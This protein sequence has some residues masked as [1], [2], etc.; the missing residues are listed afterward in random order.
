MQRFSRSHAIATEP[1]QNALEFS[2]DSYS[3]G[4]PKLRFFIWKR[5]GH[6]TEAQLQGQAQ[7][8]HIAWPSPQDPSEHHSTCWTGLLLAALCP[9]RCSSKPGGVSPT[10]KSKLL[11]KPKCREP[12]LQGVAGAPVPPLAQVTFNTHRELC[13]QVTH[14]DGRDSLLSLGSHSQEA[15]VHPRRYCKNSEMREL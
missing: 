11:P 10:P 4:V 8:R 14:V 13:L 1:S 7:S 12:Q 3:L 15:S 5:W 6:S 9:G 2:R